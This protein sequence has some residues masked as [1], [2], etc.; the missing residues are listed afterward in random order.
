MNGQ[1]TN[2]KILLVGSTRSLRDGSYPELITRWEN[3]QNGEVI[4]KQLCE[5]I[6]DGATNL[7]PSSFD[8]VHLIVEVEDLAFDKTTSS[9]AVSSFVQTIALSLKSTGKL[10]WTI[11]TGNNQ[12]ES[13]LKECPM[14]SDIKVEKLTETA[15][16][17]TASRNYE[18][19]STLGKTSSQAVELKL[20][21]RTNKASLWSF[22]SSDVDLIDESTLLTEEDLQR[23][24]VTASEACNP[25]KAKKACKNCTCGLRELELMEEDDLPDKLKNK[26][27][28]GED[29]KKSDSTKL[30]V[31]GISGKGFTSSCGSCY[32]GDAFRC[33][34]CPY[35]G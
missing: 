6:T 12:L 27:L 3:P 25:K 14:V 2:H 8:I 35:L 15:Q 1:R 33:S 26:T 5:R 29:Q 4:E 24:T 13:A 11:R 31:T 30:A 34:S 19:N 9:Q 16:R 7:S 21:E 20:P 10:S 18:S 17:I 32:L 22:T 28:N 23:P